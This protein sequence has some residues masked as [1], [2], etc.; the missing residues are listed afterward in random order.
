MNS[1]E[2]REFGDAIEKFLWFAIGVFSG[3]LYIAQ[4]M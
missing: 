2:S 1:R 3:I 4:R